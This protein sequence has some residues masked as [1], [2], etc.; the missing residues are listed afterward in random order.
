MFAIKVSITE[1]PSTLLVCLTK[2]KPNDKS[3][4]TTL[5]FSS[6]KSDIPVASSVYRKEFDLCIG[7]VVTIGNNGITLN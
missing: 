2:Y 1:Y 7:T 4:N 6:V 5:P 3:S